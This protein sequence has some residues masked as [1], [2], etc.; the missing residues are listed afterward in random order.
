MATVGVGPKHLYGFHR[1]VAPVG[2]VVQAADTVDG[3]PTLLHPSE[4]LVRVN[5]FILDST[6]AKQLCPKHTPAAAAAA[7]EQVALICSS[8]GKMHNPVT[9]SGGVLLGTVSELGADCQLPVQVGDRIVPLASLT[10][11]PLSLTAVY[12]FHDEA[13]QVEGTAVLFASSKFA[14]VPP[15]ISAAVAVLS[16]DISSLVPQVN[17]AIMTLVRERVDAAAAAAAAAATGVGNDRDSSAQP[18]I[19]VYVQGAGK[20]G[21]AA[22]AT[23]RQMQRAIPT[24]PKVTILVSDYS[25]SCLFCEW[26]MLTEHGWLRHRQRHGRRLAHLLLS[27]ARV[28][29]SAHGLAVCSS[30]FIQ[31]LENKNTLGAGPRH[32]IVSTCCPSRIINQIDVTN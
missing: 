29:A 28:I 2:A 8:R 12:G 16:L 1:V 21:L 18:P 6:S 17:R 14:I 25:R 31:H 27:S 4:C 19:I 23:I 22:M 20:S 9:N 5:R 11:I 10:C 24:F 7:A 26:R 30:L 15:D 3:S 32:T 13:V